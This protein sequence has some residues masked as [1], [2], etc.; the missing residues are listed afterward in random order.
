VLAWTWTAADKQFDFVADPGVFTSSVNIH[1]DT[2]TDDL[3]TWYQQYLRT[4]NPLARTWAQRWRDYFVN[5]YPADL[6]NEDINYGYDHVYGQGLVLWAV[7]ENDAAAMAAAES[8]GDIVIGNFGGSLPPAVGSV[9]NNGGRDIARW[10]ILF[11]YLAQG[12]GKSKWINWRNALIDRYANA[13]NWQEAPT[14]GIVQGGHYFCNRAWMSQNGQGGTGAYD[15][16]RRSN[17]VFMYGLHAEAVWRAFLATGRADMRDRL[18]KMARFMQYYGHNPAYAVPFTGGF[19]GHENGQYWHRDGAGPTNCSY[20]ASVVN[21]LVWGY[22]LT[23]DANLLTRAHAHFRQTTR[24]REGGPGDGSAALVGPTDVFAFVDTRR[25][26]DLIY[27]THN[28]GQLQYCYQLF[29]NGGAPAR[30]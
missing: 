4:G 2:E 17:S 23:G 28:R 1:E 20:D 6:Q 9:G 29:E 19:M 16:G 8:I 7:K 15:A 26:L 13:T 3:W 5:Y 12:T 24:W 11:C 18:I 21:T 10:L 14:L 27:F 25:N 22:K 30:I